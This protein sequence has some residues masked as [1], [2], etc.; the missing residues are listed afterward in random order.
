MEEQIK[1]PR[2][3]RTKYD[4]VGKTFGKLTAIEYI[5]RS[6]WR[7]RCECGNFTNAVAKDLISGRRKSCGCLTKDHPTT[8][9]DL[10]GM[11]FGKWTVIYKANPKN[12]ATVW[13]CKCDCGT[14]K[15]V[16]GRSLTNGLS[17]SCGCLKRPSKYKDLTGMKFNN[18]TVL[19][20]HEIDKNDRAVWECKCDCG[21]I[22][23]VLGKRLLNNN[24]KSCG[25]R[26]HLHR[27][28]DLTGNKYGHLTVLGLDHIKSSNQSCFW[29]CLCDA[30]GST[31]VVNG[32]D[33][34]QGKI[35][36]CGCI[37]I[38]HRGSK[39]ELEIKDYLIG[40]MKIRKEM[41]NSSASSSREFGGQDI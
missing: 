8:F 30:C 25:C 31:K 41:E 21:N 7:C 34:K 24:T 11:K 20:L 26:R 9:K 3:K 38:S 36:S 33:M 15:D 27:Y 35:Y 4:L 6:R 1:K 23:N 40:L 14:E 12:G 16:L 2:V 5:G 39:V 17:T 29:K 32:S 19:K 10:T 28:K 22:V 13:H 18:L 37:N